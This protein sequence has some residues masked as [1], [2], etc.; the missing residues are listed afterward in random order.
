MFLLPLLVNGYSSGYRQYLRLKDECGG[1]MTSC[2]CKPFGTCR[3]NGCPA[4][5]TAPPAPANMKAFCPERLCTCPEGTRISGGYGDY[6][7]MGPRPEI[8][9]PDTSG[10]SKDEAREK[11]REYK[12]KVMEAYQKWYKTAK[13]ATC[14]CTEKQ[15]DI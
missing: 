2:M 8:E 11:R 9:R 14:N 10:L 7:C 1:A 3:G 15:K 5:F 4:Y 13:D 12:E 6:E